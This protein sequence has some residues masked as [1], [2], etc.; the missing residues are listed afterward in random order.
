MDATNDKNIGLNIILVA[1][2]PVFVHLVLVTVDIFKHGPITFAT[3]DLSLL[4]LL[5]AII[6]GT[7]S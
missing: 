4:I 6:L 3:L 5:F 7:S 1:L 2:L